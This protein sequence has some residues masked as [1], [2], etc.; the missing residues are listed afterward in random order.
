MQFASRAKLVKT[1][2]TV[3]EVVDDATRI[4]R[5]KKELEQL[6]EKQTRLSTG[7]NEEEG[8]RIE[9]EKNNLL[10]RLAALQRE[11]DQQKVCHSLMTRS[12]VRYSKSSELH[13]LRPYYQAQLE[14][15]RGLVGATE[16]NVKEPSEAEK[17]R[18]KKRQRD[19]W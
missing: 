19:T 16:E 13:S 15:L 6:K 14:C 2:A 7:M 4:K 8:A 11:K 18:R 1:H 5:L 9:D 12:F 17:K 3:N 10:S